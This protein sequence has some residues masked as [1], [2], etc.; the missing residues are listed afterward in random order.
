[1]TALGR[2]RKVS[3]KLSAAVV[4]RSLPPTMCIS[5][6]ANEKTD[7]QIISVRAGLCPKRTPEA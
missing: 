3:V 2:S 6:S 5:V 4:C 1:M 7:A